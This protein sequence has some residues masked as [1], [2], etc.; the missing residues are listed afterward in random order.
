M[1]FPWAPVA[2]PEKVANS[3]Q[4]KARDFF[5]SLAHPEAKSRFIYPGAPYRFSRSPWNIQRRAP[6]IGE[7]NTRVYHQELGFSQE[8]LNELSSR[9]VI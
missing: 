1:H 9:N 8:K 7:H 4:L 5:V 2:S 6:L 3:P